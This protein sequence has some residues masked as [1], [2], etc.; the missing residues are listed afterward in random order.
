MTD[1][2]TLFDLSAQL[3]QRKSYKKYNFCDWFFNPF[4]AVLH[5]SGTSANRTRATCIILVTDFS[6]HFELS[7]QLYQRKWKRTRVFP[8]YFQLFPQVHQLKV[9][10]SNK[11]H[12]LWPFFRPIFRW[13]WVEIIEPQSKEHMYANLITGECVWDPPPGVNM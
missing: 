8:S 12:L 2:P 13:E 10:T 6:T 4:S 11:H 3:Y 7:P 5:P 9:Y 1:F